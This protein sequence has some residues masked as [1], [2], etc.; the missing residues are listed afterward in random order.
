MPWPYCV[1]SFILTIYFV[2]KFW[3]KD[4][5]SLNIPFSKTGLGGRSGECS[6][7]T[8]SML[9]VLSDASSDIECLK[10]DS[11]VS[12]SNF[13]FPSKFT[14]VLP[15]ISWTDYERLCC[16]QVRRDDIGFH[17]SVRMT[18]VMVLLRGHSCCCCHS[19][20]ILAKRRTEIFNAEHEMIDTFFFMS[21]NI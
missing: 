1:H 18:L 19:R 14:S 9:S 10:M 7:S 8:I 6:L 20:L 16:V 12:H 4:I 11:K 21:Q 17:T 13:L 5:F 3:K 15:G 2:S